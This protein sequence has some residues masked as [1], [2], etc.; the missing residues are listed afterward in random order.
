M[1]LSEFH[2]ICAV[3]H[4]ALYHTAHRVLSY[5]QWTNHPFVYSILSLYYIYWP[6]CLYLSAVNAVVSPLIVRTKSV[7]T[8]PRHLTVT[9]KS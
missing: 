9:Y 4:T 6:V 1:S 5:K 8:M 3:N 2:T 7:S